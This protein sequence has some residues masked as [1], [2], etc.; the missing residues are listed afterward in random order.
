MHVRLLSV[1][2]PMLATTACTAP[3]PATTD[4]AVEIERSYWQMIAAVSAR[5]FDRAL[6]M[7]TDD[8]VLLAPDGRVLRGRDE[9]A[10]FLAS[11]PGTVIRDTRIETIAVDGSG[12]FAYH[13]GRYAFT[14]AEAGVQRAVRGRYL[15]VWRRVGRAWRVAADMW[16]V[17][18]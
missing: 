18:E 12:D 3:A 4:L 10:A 2:L 5:D 7:Y 9:I 11:P 16:D 15:M 13:A 1:L 6:A 17:E 8:A 14:L